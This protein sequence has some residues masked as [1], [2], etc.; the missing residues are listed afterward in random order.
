MTP[1]WYHLPVSTPFETDTMSKI[2]S[3]TT[4][5]T[6]FQNIFNTAL[7]AYKK[8]TKKDLLMHPLSAKLQHCHSPAAILSV[9]QELVQ[10]FNQCRCRNKRLRSCLKPIVNVLYAFSTTIGEGVGLVCPKLQSPY[11]PRSDHCLSGISPSKGDIC[12][13]WCP[14]LGGLASWFIGWPIVMLASVGCQGC[15]CQP[16]CPGWYFRVDWRLF[17]KAQVICRS[18]TN[19]CNDRNDCEDPSWSTC[20][21]CDRHQGDQT[22]VTKW[23]HPQQPAIFY[24]CLFRKI[25]EEASWEEQNGGCV[26]EARFID[27]RGGSNGNNRSAENYK[28]H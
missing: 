19:C 13:N 9:L 18:V 27:A 12:W 15:Q 4:S 1:P 28:R 17:Q 24:S 7:E 14:Y 22:G 3:T 21:S 10:Q 5:S 16:G 8:K 20:Y 11:D 6:N 26:E 2:S 23:V 25:L